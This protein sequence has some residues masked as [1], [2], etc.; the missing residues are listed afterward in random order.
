MAEM[1][2]DFNTAMIATEKMQTTLKPDE[3]ALKLAIMADL[4]GKTSAAYYGQYLKVS[5]DDENKKLVAAEMVRKSKT[6]EKEIETYRP[7]LEKSPQL[8]AQLYSETFAK[9]SSAGILNKVV[10]DSKLKNTDS[11]KLMSRVAFL[12]EFDAFQLKLTSHKLDTSN[13]RKLA[14]SIKGRA[15]LL[16]KMEAMTKTAIQ[17]GDW[18]SQLVSIDLLAKESERF[19]QELISAPMPQGLTG[20]EESEYLNLL[21]AQAAPFQTKAADAKAKTE[22]FWKNSQ[23]MPSLK[24]SWEQ[25]P[26]RNLVAVEIAAL[27]KIAPAA[28]QSDLA[29]FDV[30]QIDRTEAAKAERPSMQEVQAA[31]SK[32]HQDPMSASA[33]KNLMNLEKKSDNTAMVQYLQTRID[34]L[35]N[36]SKREIQ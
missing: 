2:L 20:D 31:R 25:K 29:M 28:Y 33:L 22:Q 10:K 3:K 32:V 19:Y 30:N 6:P 9:N 12:K 17:D 26:L 4:S 16:D 27:K 11:G 13:D 24:A 35:N 18:T 8:M 14:A 15:A 36:P 5:K 34:N 1:M 23:W 7:Y 21:S